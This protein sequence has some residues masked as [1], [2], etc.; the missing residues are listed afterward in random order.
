MVNKLIELKMKTPDLP[1]FKDI[2]ELME[3]LGNTSNIGKS[4]KLGEIKKLEYVKNRIQELEKTAEGLSLYQGSVY[5]DFIYKDYKYDLSELEFKVS[6]QFPDHESLI[7]WCKKY[8]I[9]LPKKSEKTADVDNNGVCTTTLVYEVK[10]DDVIYAI[11]YTREG[12]PGHKCRIE[13][14]TTKSIVCDI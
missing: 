11:S 5:I 14:Y 9:V 1:I 13:T 7:R 8:K 12:L 6:R 2:D 3:R 4:L 10:V